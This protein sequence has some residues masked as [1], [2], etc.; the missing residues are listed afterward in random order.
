MQ[1]L[2]MRIRRVAADIT[3]EPSKELRSVADELDV[4]I[5]KLERRRAEIQ[6]VNMNS[7]RLSERVFIGRILH[8]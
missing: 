8:R 3:E 6:T 1:D 7:A 2:V 4:I 5:A